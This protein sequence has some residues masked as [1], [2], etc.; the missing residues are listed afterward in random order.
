VAKIGNVVTTLLACFPAQFQRFVSNHALQSGAILDPVD[1]FVEIDRPAEDR[2]FGNIYEFRSFAQTHA[3]ILN[4]YV[5]YR[6]Q[7]L[8]PRGFF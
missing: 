2:R 5:D 3:K 8:A 6:S 1:V 7:D 4:H